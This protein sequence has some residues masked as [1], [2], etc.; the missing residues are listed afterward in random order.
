MEA[1]NKSNL[2]ANALLAVS[3]ANAQAAALER[4]ATT[5]PFS[6]W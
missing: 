1:D 2:G 4:R 5:V 6:R 3:L